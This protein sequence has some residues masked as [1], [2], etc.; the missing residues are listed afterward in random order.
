MSPVNLWVDLSTLHLPSPMKN[1]VFDP[2]KEMN[3]TNLNV[4]PSETLVL[5]VCLRERFEVSNNPAK[6]K[7]VPL[8]VFTFLY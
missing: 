5:L 6:K 4:Q 3:V 8:P 1:T 7:K 2:E